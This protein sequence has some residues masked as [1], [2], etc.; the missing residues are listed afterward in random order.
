MTTDAAKP[1]W[2]WDESLRKLEARFASPSVPLPR[3]VSFD[4]FDTLIFR[5][6]KDPSDLFIE[7]GRQLDR[8][9]QLRIPLTPS[10]F[11]SVRISAEERARQRVARAGRC[12]EL[13][14]DAIY[15]ELGEVLSDPAA[16]RE[17]EFEIERSLCVLNPAVA[18]LIEHVRRLG[19]RTAII[20]DTYFRSTELLRLLEER[21]FAPSL[22]DAVFASC[23][24]GHAKWHDGGLFQDVLRRFD[25]HP[26]E[27]FHI[28]DNHKADIAHARRLGIDA[29]HYYRTTTSLV[30]IFHGEQRL[31]GQ[32]ESRAGSLETLRVMV[33][34]RARDDGDAFR[35]GALVLGPVLAR[36]A[37]WC[38]ERYARAGVTRVLALM[39]EGELLGDLLRRS[40]AVS[41][42]PLD[43]VTCYASR[44]S[45]ARA[46]MS[47]INAESAAGL[48]EGSEQVSPQT[49]L[50]ILGLSREGEGFLDPESRRRPL[51]S[52][53]ASLR[54]L[55]MLFQLPA[56]R[57]LVELRRR[58]SHQLAFEYFAEQVGDASKIGILDL[59]WS[60]S[61]QRNIANILRQGG[62][63]VQTIGCYLGCT[64]RAGRLALEGHQVHAYLDRPWNR[65][66]I[67]AELCINAC[68]GS[69]SGYARDGAGRVQPSLDAYD[70][71][72]EETAVKARLRDGVLAFQ[73]SWLEEKQRN[74][75]TWSAELLDDI[76]RMS[77]AILFRWMDLPIK[78]EADR[79][80]VLRHEENY[81][82]SV[83]NAPLC[84]EASRVRFRRGG[85]QALYS[86]A[87]C[88][89][90]QGV[91]VQVNPRVM[92]VVRNGLD[93]ALSLGSLGSF[94]AAGQETGGL[95]I[96]EMSS[97]DELL[98]HFGPKQ[99]VFL[100]AAAPAG[101]VD[102]CALGAGDE[103]VLAAGFPRLILGGPLSQPPALAE[104]RALLQPGAKAALVLTGDVSELDARTALHGLA[105]FLGP[106]GII[107]VSVGRYDRYDAEP[108]EPWSTGTDNPLEGAVRSWFESTSAALG[109]GIWEPARVHRRNW[110]ILVHAPETMFSMAPWMPVVTDL[111]YRDEPRPGA[112]SGE[113]LQSPSAE[114]LAPGLSSE[115]GRPSAPPFAAVTAAASDR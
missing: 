4:F 58:E 30:T 7:L 17:L 45:T 8:R 51:P 9:G 68:V 89:W 49:I 113:H 48:L 20:S 38:V 92:S 43:I 81:F 104:I 2:M 28:G 31:A 10:E 76:D 41:G 66:A 42:V 3:V 77:H 109:Y 84:D 13:G 80:G 103:T 12:P 55:N 32:G 16:A 61:I 65:S 83:N 69:T 73:A 93:D 40:A 91:M 1:A 60:G 5:L 25:L 85:T 52:K 87:S 59:G 88:Y 82:G 62:R 114:G 53:E 78:A 50:D 67:L 14:L 54:F 21:G 100:G 57:Q 112:A 107:L 6:C 90:P 15:A 105:P 70:G 39:R 63:A 115:G 24:L 72:P 108:R 47:G 36:F 46:A 11:R 101:L 33:A 64:R 44:M 29:L 79:L 98:H 110:I 19:C 99:I 34:R 106:G 18:S 27:L 94:G 102:S 37:D 97:L 95:T 111:G 56:L 23:E 86:D 96:D 74:G 71:T 26:G 35:D 22:L 75:R